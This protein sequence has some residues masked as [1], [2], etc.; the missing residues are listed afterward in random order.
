MERRAFLKQ[1]LYTVAAGASVMIGLKAKNVEAL[2][3]SNQLLAQ[4]G[5][6]LPSGCRSR[7][8]GLTRCKDHTGSC[9]GTHHACSGHI[10]YKGTRGC[11]EGKTVQ[12]SKH[13][14]QEE[15]TH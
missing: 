15:T 3:I 4:S 14:R 11:G 7:A 13:G 8:K 2:S 1:V 10:P 9:E 5:S 6:E 12:C